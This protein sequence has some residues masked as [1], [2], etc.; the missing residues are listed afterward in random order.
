[1]LIHTDGA[2]GTHKFLTWLTSQR[3]SYSVG[4][5]LPGTFTQTLE[6]IPVQVRGGSPTSPD[7]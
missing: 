1:M 2:G 7:Y 5:I 3:L 4:F 6:H